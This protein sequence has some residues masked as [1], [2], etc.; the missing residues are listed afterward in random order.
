M[1][2]SEEKTR[3]VSQEEPHLTPCLGFCQCPVTGGVFK[4]SEGVLCNRKETDIACFLESRKGLL[5]NSF[6]CTEF[7][8]YHVHRATEKKWRWLQPPSLWRRFCGACPSLPRTEAHCSDSSFSVGPW[9]T[10]AA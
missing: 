6:L 3:R 8:P 9:K 1:S 10:K 7:A 5:L 2:G 4:A